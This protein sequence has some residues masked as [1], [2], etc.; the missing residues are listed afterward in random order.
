M[1]KTCHGDTGGQITWWAK[2]PPWCIQVFIVIVMAS[3]VCII[4]DFANWS[5][6][7]FPSCWSSNLAIPYFS[8]SAAVPLYY[9]IRGVRIH[10]R[11]IREENRQKRLLPSFCKWS[12][13]EIVW[14][15]C[16]HGFWVNMIGSFAGFIALAFIGRV[17]CGLT[18]DQVTIGVAALFTFLGLLAITGVT[19][20]LPEILY[21][22][23]LFNKKVV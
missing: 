4:M 23:S 18:P 13:S 1:N 10:G 14:I 22:G 21:R 6:S 3:I 5:G 12:D 17:A 19:G 8:L 20:I 2:T 15:H 11:G 16:I 7:L 9:G